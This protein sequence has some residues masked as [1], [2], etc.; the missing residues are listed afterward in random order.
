MLG[1]WCAVQYCMGMFTYA[2][3]C[4]LYCIVFSQLYCMSLPVMYLWFTYAVLCLLYCIVFSQLYCMSLPVMYLWFNYVYSIALCFPSCTACL[5]LWFTYVYSTELCFPSCA[6][7]YCM[8]GLSN[9]ANFFAHCSIIL[10]YQISPIIHAVSTHY[11]FHM[12]INYTPLFS[13]NSFFPRIN[14]GLQ[15]QPSLGCSLTSAALFQ[16]KILVPSS[17]QCHNRAISSLLGSQPCDFLVTI[18]WC[19]INVQR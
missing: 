17:E 6:V 18:Y 1:H 12:R 4:L 16:V 19:L 13:D 10:C 5:Y 7:Q 2:L 3:L 11:S 9:C 15:L 14:F 8:Q